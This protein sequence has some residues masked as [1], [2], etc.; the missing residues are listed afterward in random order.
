MLTIPKFSTD[1]TSKSLRRTSKRHVLLPSAHMSDSG[2]VKL[3]TALSGASRT[4]LASA[5]DANASMQAIERQMRLLT[6]RYSA[7]NSTDLTPAKRELVTQALLDVFRGSPQTVQVKLAQAVHALDNAAESMGLVA[8]DLLVDAY[9]AEKPRL[10]KYVANTRAELASRAAIAHQSRRFEQLL[11]ESKRLQATQ[12][13][14]AG[15]TAAGAGAETGSVLGLTHGRRTLPLAS[16]AQQHSRRERQ[17][18]FEAMA[19]A[20]IDRQSMEAE[21][22]AAAIARNEARMEQRRARWERMRKEFD[23]AHDGVQHPRAQTQRHEPERPPS[24]MRSVGS[25][26]WTYGMRLAS[27]FLPP[28]PA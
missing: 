3:M 21:D 25:V 10:E 28:V 8:W 9:R 5:G 13:K 16:A 24:R 26:V 15:N 27:K 6:T 7:A 11:A 14:M 18:V 20:A 4:P 19:A 1:V 17:R 23:A 12:T 22:A 2:F